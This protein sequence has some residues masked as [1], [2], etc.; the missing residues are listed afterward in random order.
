MNGDLDRFALYLRRVFK[1]PC[2]VRRVGESREQPSI[3]TS[4]LV[5]SL[6]WGAVLRVPSWHQL[7]A[8]TRRKRWQRQVNW[9]QPISDDTFHYASERLDVADLRQ[10]LVTTNKILKRNKAFEANKYQGLLVASLDG[11]E[12]FKSRSRCCQDCCQRTITLKKAAGPEEKITEYYHYQVV[13]Q[14]SGPHL[15]VIL[16]F[17]SKREGE[18]E[19]AAALRLLQ[20]VREHYGPRF[21]DVVAVDAGFAE[22]PFIRQVETMGWSVV[23]VLK[24][25]RYEIWQEAQRLTA[26]QLPLE[27]WGKPTQ[28]QVELWE[29]KALPFT[30]SHGGTMR[31]V[32]SREQGLEVKQVAGKR[33]RI[34]YERNWCWLASKELDPY[35]AKTIWAIG[36]ARWKIENNA[37]NELTQH[38]QLEHCTHH[39]PVAIAAWLLIVIW[40]FN[41][42]HAYAILCAKSLRFGKTTLQELRRRIDLAMST[43]Q[44]VLFFSG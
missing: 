8:E 31:V 30:D 15:S 21:F 4:A 24:Q 20:R 34:G 16:D 23:S 26:G 38:W 6:F 1:F 12:Q 28:E 3:P 36:H 33:Q 5:L 41:L 11:N 14:L 2:L 17:E 35:A 27:R 39:H 25:E 32:R 44:A 10:V 40:A 37:F 42:F 43:D 13:C 7:E 22:G 29:V 9:F 18:D 19:V